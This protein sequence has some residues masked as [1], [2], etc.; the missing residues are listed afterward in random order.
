MKNNKSW[1]GCEEP[2]TL[3]PHWWEYK[4]A[5]PGGKVGNSSRS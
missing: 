5:A 4:L 2:G 3:I 1:Q